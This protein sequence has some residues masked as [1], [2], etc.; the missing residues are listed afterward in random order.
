MLEPVL[1]EPLV[2]GIYIEAEQFLGAREA[3]KPLEETA[4]EAGKS[5]EE[6]A[7]EA[8][9]HLEE[10]AGELVRRCHEAG[11]ACFLA[12]PDIFRLRERRWYEKA[13]PVLAAAGFEGMLVKNLDEAGFLRSQGFQGLWMADAGLYT[14]NKEARRTLERLGASGFTLPYEL[15]E[16][17]LLVR[18]SAG[19][20]LVVYGHH[21][22]MITANCVAK[23]L[24]QCKGK[25]G[26]LYLEDRFQ[27]RL[28]V[29]RF[30]GSCHNVIYNPKPL[31]LL[32]CSKE[33]SRLRPGSL[34]LRFTI[35]NQE[36][37][38]RILSRAVGILKQGGIAS[39]A[40]EA[41]TRGHLRRGVE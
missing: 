8:G 37:L 31:Y 29:K 9:K 36:E 34:R 33:L 4:R 39:G 12:L 19:E 20:E 11:K 22:M 5:L 10:T 35:E 41:F 26:V 1:R 3:G 16:R 13:Y 21:P 23:T 24:G 28:P 32:D 27:N 18:G 30:C 2:D 40:P 25:P 38:L 6:T 17:E 14:F 15:R 7:G